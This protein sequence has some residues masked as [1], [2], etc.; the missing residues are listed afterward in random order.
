ME[1]EGFV[2]GEG[3]TG[4]E[5]EKKGGENGS[6]KLEFRIGQGVRLSNGTD[7]ELLEKV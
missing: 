2:G 4:G 5:D 3:S 6:L 7:I 1:I